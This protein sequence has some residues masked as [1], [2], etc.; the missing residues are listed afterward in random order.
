MEIPRKLCPRCQASAPVEAGVCG[1]CG[2]QYRTHFTPHQV[3]PAISPP[4]QAKPVDGKVNRVL[5]T[6]LA[7]LVAVGSFGT[8][9]WMGT[10]PKPDKPA[11]RTTIHAQNVAPIERPVQETPIELPKSTRLDPVEAEARRALERAKRN[12]DIPLADTT[13][14]DSDGRIHLRG[15]GS[16]SKDDWNA[17]RN[18][19][20]NSPILKQ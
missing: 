19:V 20:Q 5:I 14:K 10:R 15:G 3:Q 8:V 9:I 13:P 1:K 4:L 18:A 16:V 17:A 6:M 7:T 2:H 11:S 12:I